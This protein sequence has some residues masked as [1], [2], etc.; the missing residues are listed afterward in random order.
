VTVPARAA[1]WRRKA[2]AP[3][4]QMSCARSRQ[5]SALARSR[6][7]ASIGGNAC[8]CCAANGWIAP[9]GASPPFICRGRVHFGMASWWWAKLGRMSAPRERYHLSAPAKRGRGTTR[10]VVEGASE[11][12]MMRAPRKTIDHAQQLRRKLSAPEAMLWSR[13]RKR[14]P[15]TPVFRRQHPIG[16]YVLDFYC[17]KARLAIELDGAG[18][19]MGD[20][21]QR[22]LRRTAWLEARGITVMR[23]PANDL[24]RRLDDAADAVV[25]MAVDLL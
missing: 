4:T 12:T 17:A 23:I 16:P 18:H 3:C 15:G 10:S 5:Q 8:R 14:A 1:A 11:Q 20:R 21:P 22:D 13:L 19:D 25:R 7:R 2:G 6:A 9:F 24:T